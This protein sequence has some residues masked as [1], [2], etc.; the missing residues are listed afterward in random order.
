MRTIK[1]K[2]AFRVKR[3]AQGKI[4]RYK[5]RLVALGNLQKPGIDY[6]NTF[7][8]VVRMR[9][10]RTLIALAVEKGWTIEHDDVIAAYLAGNLD[11]EIFMEIPDGYKE[12]GCI[13][14]TPQQRNTPTKW[15]C[16]LKKGLYGLHQSGL[17]WYRK[18]RKTLLSMGLKQSKADPCVFYDPKGDL[19]ITTYVDDLMYYGTKEKIEVAKKRL[20]KR[21]DIRHLGIAKLVQSIRIRHDT[22]GNIEIDQ[23]AYIMDI[24][25]EFHMSA[26]KPLA[27]PGVPGEFN[28]KN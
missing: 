27:T 25:R 4:A 17:L 3:D 15:V 19:I 7:S 18:L 12:F 6:D 13:L 2:W 9:T 22:N 5:A 21:F 8:P 23:S 10:T 1:S 16:K 20:A 28:S 14:A 24:L 11:D 26:C